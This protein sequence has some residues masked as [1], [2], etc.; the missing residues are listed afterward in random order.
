MATN[1]Q[2]TLTI[3][4]LAIQDHILS[5]SFLVGWS[6]VTLTKFYT[7]VNQSR[8]EIILYHEYDTIRTES[9][10]CSSNLKLAY[11]NFFF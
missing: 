2:A 11:M 6:F 4:L 1:P 8:C 3:R 9:P 10:Q 7:P 5:R